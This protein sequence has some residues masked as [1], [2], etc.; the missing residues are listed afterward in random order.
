MSFESDRPCV[1]CGI[2]GEGLVT[3]HHI[4]T[5][6]AFPEYRESEFNLI[7]VCQAHH[8]LFH[9]HGTTYMADTFWTVKA[10]LKAHG[11]EIND[12]TGKWSH[13]K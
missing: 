2:Y 8:N 3:Y 13:Q 7:S 1:V 4:Y 10:W 6:K 9:S 12:F 11:W 5:K